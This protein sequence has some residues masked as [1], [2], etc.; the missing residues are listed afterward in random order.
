MSVLFYNNSSIPILFHYQKN[1]KNYKK[2]ITFENREMFG[3]NNNAT[4]NLAIFL[5][6]FYTYIA[7]H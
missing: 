5:F 7:R 6:L 4:S 2:Q 1:K 3:F